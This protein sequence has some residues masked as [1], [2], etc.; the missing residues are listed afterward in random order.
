V[1][2]KRHEL[3]TSDTDHQIKLEDSRKSLVALEAENSRIQSDASAYG[4]G[5]VVNAL[6]DADPKIVQALAATGMQPDALIAAAM[7][8]FADNAEKIGQ[9]NISPDMLSELMRK[10]NGG[11]SFDAGNIQQ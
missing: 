8:E 6:K 5:T 9:L 4:L 7:R 2:E 10:S 11:Q 3:E 1:Q